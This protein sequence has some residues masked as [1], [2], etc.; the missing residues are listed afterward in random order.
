MRGVTM[1]GS[2]S[3]YGSLLSHVSKARHGAPG[4]WF[5]VFPC[6]RIEIL[7]LRSG[8]APGYPVSVVELFADLLSGVT[9]M[10]FEIITIFPGFFAGIFEHGIVRRAQ[11]EGLVS[12]KTARSARVHA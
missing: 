6:L 2:V 5:N 11:A 1:S 9:T 3:G 12:V 7:R 10:R 8:Q 4:L